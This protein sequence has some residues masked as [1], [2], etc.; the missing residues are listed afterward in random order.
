MAKKRL[1]VGDNDAFGVASLQGEPFSLGSLVGA[2]A[3]SAAAEPTKSVEP[4]GS[5]A[6]TAPKRQTAAATSAE[7]RVESGSSV[8]IRA[9][10]PPPREPTASVPRPDVSNRP[11]AETIESVRDSLYIP[12]SLQERVQRAAWWLR[13]AKNDI[14]REGIEERIAELESENGGPFEPIPSAKGLRRG[15]R[16]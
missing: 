1:P 10:D 3:A 6:S 12:K 13:A 7:Q 4:N 11:T 9:G 8:P 2:P 16:S 14:Y 5:A 15:R